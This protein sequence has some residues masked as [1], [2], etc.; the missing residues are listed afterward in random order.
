MRLVELALGFEGLAMLRSLFEDDPSSLQ[1]RLE[2]IARFVQGADEPPLGFALDFPERSVTEGYADWA[3]TYD[4][5]PNGLITPSSAWSR[6]CFVRAGR[7][8]RSTR[9]AAP[10][11]W[12]VSWSRPATTPLT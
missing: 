5:M 11:G 8:G 10:A 2:D 6:A 4:T 12:P 3:G 9:P 7:G 1:A